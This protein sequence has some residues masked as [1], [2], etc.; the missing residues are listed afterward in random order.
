MPVYNLACRRSLDPALRHR[1]ASVVT[2]T[3]CAQTGAPAAFVNVMFVDNYPLRDRLEI[4]A[5]GGVRNDG[6]RTPENIEQLRTA[7]R[8]AI[9]DAAQLPHDRVRVALVGV[10]SSWVMEGG[11]IMPPPGSEAE[12]VRRDSTS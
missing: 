12:A 1:I 2:E 11:E 10:P 8:A 4:D 7:L 9:A 3:H 5:M 6:N